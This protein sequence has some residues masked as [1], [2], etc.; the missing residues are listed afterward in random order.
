MAQTPGD[1]PHILVVD[2]DDRIR[3][4]LKR[5]L[6]ERG[7]RVSTAPNA[8]KA[9]S[10]LNS[11]A[12]DLLVLDV[13]MP[14]M[15]GFELTQA[16]RERGETP[17][18][19]LTARGD[20]EDRIKGLSLGA[21]DYLPKPFEPEE[22]V[23]RINA[24]LRRAKPA[25]AAIQHVSFGD[26]RFDIQRESLTRSGDAVRLTGGEAALLAALA[27]SAGQTVSR[28]TLSERTGGGERAVD[29]QVTRLRRKLETD[30][31][32]P[33]HLQTVRGEGYR[34]L[35]DPIFED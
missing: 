12:F 27:A 11:L 14:G 3:N 1:D 22:L 17:I 19:L 34:L 29:V 15:D 9:L 13:M 25:Q 8:N 2:D 28:L 35:A 26:W 5:F 24:I 33:L 18:L 21:D 30:P 32:E 16:V 4:L 7:Y 23:L 20:A 10:T 6:Q 31:K